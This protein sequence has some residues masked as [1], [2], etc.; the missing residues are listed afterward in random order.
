MS[1]AASRELWDSQTAYQVANA[2]A[3][4]APATN[5]T[6]VAGLFANQPAFVRRV[7]LAMAFEPPRALARGRRTKPVGP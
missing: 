5:A 2:E 3:P 6:N 1:M 4:S 7:A